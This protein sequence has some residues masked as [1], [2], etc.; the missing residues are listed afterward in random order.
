MGSKKTKTESLQINMLNGCGL[1]HFERARTFVC[2]TVLFYSVRSTH[3]FINIH[4]FIYLFVGHSEEA[5]RVTE[6]RM[7]KQH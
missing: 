7:L 2:A 5:S 3:I 1:Y 6:N 4:L